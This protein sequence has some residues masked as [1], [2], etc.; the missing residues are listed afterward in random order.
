MTMQ[1]ALAR[2]LD[3]H[4]LS[5]AQAR[6]VMNEVMEGDATPAQIG[7]LLVAL[8]LKGETAD[9]IAGCAEAMRS[10]VLAVKPKRDDLVDTAGTGGDGMGTI[11][12][13]TA[14]A[15]VAAAAGAGV[16]KHG[17]RAVSSASGSADVL[18]A[19]GFRL[20]L[21]PARIERSIDE[22]GFG[23]LFAPTH[24]PAMRHAA[25]VRRELAARTVFN[26]L[27]PLTNPAGARAQVVGVYAPS[28]VRTIA[29][30][31]AQLGARRAFVVHG[32]G[33]IDELSPTGPNLVCEVVDGDV[34]EREIDPLDL[35]VP[36]CGA[37]E[38]RGGSPAE[39]ATAII[40]VFAGENGGPR[41]AILLNAAGA[42]AAAGHGRDLAEGLELAREAIDSGAAAGRLDELIAF[43]QAT[44]VPV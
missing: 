7:G 32:A 8:R 1:E 15:L 4:D 40:R 25:P 19:L 27:G 26:V 37:R 17:N 2:L 16:A 42:L 18:E 23:F 13:S 29:E 22:L 43:S 34:R 35:G 44:E 5:R 33:G 36:R 11:N 12:I 3:G 21:P 9:E 39:N 28:L 31:L 24:H 38:L 10:H 6:S 20:E 30:V 41:S 14:A